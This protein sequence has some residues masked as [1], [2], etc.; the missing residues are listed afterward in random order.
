MAAPDPTIGAAGGDA[1]AV[2]CSGTS[3]DA[4]EAAVVDGGWM[5]V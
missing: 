1:F 3:F 5:L 2:T 4:A